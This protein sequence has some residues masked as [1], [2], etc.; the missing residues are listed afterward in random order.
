MTQRR[1][2]VGT[3]SVALQAPARST[4]HPNVRGDGLGHW[5]CAPPRLC[6]LRLEGHGGEHAGE[7]AVLVGVQQVGQRQQPVPQRG[8]RQGGMPQSVAC[9]AQPAHRP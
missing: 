9:A 7:A 1:E 5:L 8:L 2:R 3:F 4:L 6:Q